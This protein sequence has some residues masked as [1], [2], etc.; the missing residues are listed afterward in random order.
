MI[1]SK[2]SRSM[3]RGLQGDHAPVIHGGHEVVEQEQEIET[4]ISELRFGSVQFCVDPIPIS[5]MSAL[6]LSYSSH[7]LFN[8][9]SLDPDLF[10]PRACRSIIQPPFISM[11][12]ALGDLSLL[13]DHDTARVQG[14]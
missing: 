10:L 6:L 1:A 12:L 2:V 7:A 4:N 11:I 13:V 9:H 5:K 14:T 8:D 3:C